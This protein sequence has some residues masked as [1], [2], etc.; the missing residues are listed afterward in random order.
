MALALNETKIPFELSVAEQI[1]DMVQEM[2]SSELYLTMLFPA[3]AKI[4]FP[5]KTGSMIL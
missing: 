1:V 3:I 4:C 2:T 5:R